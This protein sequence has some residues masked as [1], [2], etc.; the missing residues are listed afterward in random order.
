LLEAKSKWHKRRA[1]PPRDGTWSWSAGDLG[2]SPVR[3]VGVAISP[4]DG[5]LYVS[6]DNG[7]VPLQRK[8]GSTAQGALYRI[9]LARTTDG[10]ARTA[11]H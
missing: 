4:I 5:A 10:L 1:Q 6:S 7:T 11:D 2:E 9:G 8:S 3:P